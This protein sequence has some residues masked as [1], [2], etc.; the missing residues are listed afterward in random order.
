MAQVLMNRPAL[1]VMPVQE[2]PQLVQDSFLKVAPAGLNQVFTMMC[3]TWYAGRL[4]LLV[5]AT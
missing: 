5:T 4:W 3:G 2:W 1:G